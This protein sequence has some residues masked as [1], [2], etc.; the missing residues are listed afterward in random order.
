LLKVPELADGV[1]AD[2]QLA[3]FCGGGMK[4]GSGA[5]DWGTAVDRLIDMP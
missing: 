1:E 5:T 3:W 4:R 2:A